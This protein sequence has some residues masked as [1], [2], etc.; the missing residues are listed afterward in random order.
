MSFDPGSDSHREREQR[1]VKDVLLARCNR[2]VP[3]TDL[4]KLLWLSS[5]QFIAII[6]STRSTL[7]T[8]ECHSDSN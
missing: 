7:F 4:P 2:D 3:G 1:S 5:C 8:I 6:Q